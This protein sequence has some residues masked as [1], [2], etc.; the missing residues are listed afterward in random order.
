MNW[1][2]RTD[3]LRSALG[4]SGRSRRFTAETERARH[5]QQEHPGNYSSDS[6][7]P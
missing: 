1:I 6:S 2:L 7:N 3:A 5:G 4:L